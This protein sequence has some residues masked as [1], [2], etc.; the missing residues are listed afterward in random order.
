MTGKSPKYEQGKEILRPIP[1]DEFIK[2][3]ISKLPKDMPEKVK[4]KL[5]NDAK[6][7][8]GHG[9]KTDNPTK[10][11]EKIQKHQKAQKALKDISMQE[12]TDKVTKAYPNFDQYVYIQPGRDT[13]KWVQAVRE[14]QPCSISWVVSIN[15]LQE[16][17]NWMEWVFRVLTRM[18]LRDCEMRNLDLYFSLLIYFLIYRY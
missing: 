1:L 10:Y 14:S 15:P 7:F 3:R 5:L 17:I 12:K 9:E 2:K 18:N 8:A 11:L 4:K 6:F 13:K 16:I